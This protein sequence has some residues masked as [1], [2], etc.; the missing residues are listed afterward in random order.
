MEDSVTVRLPSS[1]IPRGGCGERALRAHHY[2]MTK[3]IFPILACHSRGPVWCTEL[4]PESTAT[5]TGMSSTVN[6]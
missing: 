6:S 2:W 5:V 3:G 1:I 4:P